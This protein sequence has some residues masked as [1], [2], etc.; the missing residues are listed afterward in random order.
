MFL[1][2][3]VRSLMEEPLG[4]KRLVSWFF[5]VAGASGPVPARH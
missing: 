5:S 2:A 1:E 4:P 3:Q